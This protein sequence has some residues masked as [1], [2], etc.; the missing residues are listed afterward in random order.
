V[1]PT[2]VMLSEEDVASLIS[3]GEVI[4]CVEEAFRERSTGEVQM[5]SKPYLFFREYDGDLRVMPAYMPKHGA[6]GVKIVNSHRRN[7]AD[8][9]LPSVIGTL[10]LVDP[11]TGLPQA[12]MAANSITSLRTGAAGAVAVKHLARED[13][14]VAALVGTGVQAGT[15]LRGMLEVLP[16]LERVRV[17]DLDRSRAR[18]FARD[19][20]DRVNVTAV[21]SAEHAAK[22]ADLIVTTTPSTKPVIENAWVEDGTHINAI[23]ADAPAKQELDLDIIRRAKIVVDDW[24]Q[25]S[26]G[27]EINRAVTLGLL[28]RDDIHAELPD[29]VGGKQKGRESD[30]EITVFDSTGL[31][32]Q[33]IAVGY[34]IYERALAQGIGEAAD[35]WGLGGSAD[36]G[37]LKGEGRQ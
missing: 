11:R 3:M 20:G 13:S 21:D 36:T 17:F 35:I 6:S 37:R 18:R 22:G 10:F 8:C 33:D 19:W 25:A 12:I 26:H 9:G 29:V 16:G 2:A 32:I 7:P 1:T 23:G 15:Q 27:G 24:S 14:D 30:G 5:P 4:E 34:R 31:A 28:T